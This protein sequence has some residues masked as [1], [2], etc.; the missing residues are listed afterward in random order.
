M[1][2]KELMEMSF[3]E[4]YNFIEVIEDRIDE[5]ETENNDLQHQIDELNQRDWL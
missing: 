3:N 5:L 4:I 2:T 1:E